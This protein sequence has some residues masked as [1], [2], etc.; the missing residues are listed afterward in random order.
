MTTTSEL[1]ARTMFIGAQILA[2][3]P[4]GLRG[5]ELWPLVVE[6]LP[7]GLFIH[8]YCIGRR[9]RARSLLS[10]CSHTYQSGSDTGR[11]PR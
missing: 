6:R 11:L 2:E 9:N 4:D 7:G 10:A 3:H 1:T 8:H 5:R